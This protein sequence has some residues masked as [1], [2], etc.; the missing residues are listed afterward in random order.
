MAGD[1]HQVRDETADIIAN[2]AEVGIDT[3]LNE[4]LYRDIPVLSTIIGLG[5]V[6][7]SIPDLILRAKICRF[8]TSLPSIS[9]ADRQRFNSEME[10]DPQMG[11]K[12]GQVVV[13][14]LDRFNDLAKAQ[15][16][17]KIFVAYVK[18]LITSEQLS[19]IHI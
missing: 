4:G 9:D 14:L 3:L 2:L 18:N 10:R 11:R 16:F 13:L 19:L 17:G 15:I 8:L 7:H 12:V 5:R 6:A 1:D